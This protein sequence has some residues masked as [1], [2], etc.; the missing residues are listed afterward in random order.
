MFLE[1]VE[2]GQDPDEEA[3]KLYLIRFI[4][5]LPLSWYTGCV[6]EYVPSRGLEC[7][8]CNEA[9]SLE[10]SLMVSNICISFMA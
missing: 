2:S 4:A 9:I 5:D 10:Q 3:V 7:N 1:V 6:I 8:W